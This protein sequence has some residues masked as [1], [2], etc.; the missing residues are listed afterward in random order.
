MSDGSTGENLAPG[1]SADSGG[2]VVDGDESTPTTLAHELGHLWGLGHKD[3]TGATWGKQ[4]LMYPKADSSKGLK[5]C[6]GLSAKQ[7]ST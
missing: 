5:K 4:N 2:V 7:C 1:G 6:K 3:S